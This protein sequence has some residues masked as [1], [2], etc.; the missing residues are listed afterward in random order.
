MGED[1]PF[2]TMARWLQEG[3]ANTRGESEVLQ[4]CSRGPWTLWSMKRIQLASNSLLVGGNAITSS[5]V[6]GPMCGL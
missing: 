5:S 3:S 4:A 6:G 2:E 1:C